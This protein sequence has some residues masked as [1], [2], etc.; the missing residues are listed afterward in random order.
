MAVVRAWSRANCRQSEW[1]SYADSKSG[2]PTLLQFGTFICC[3]DEMFSDIEHFISNTDCFALEELS[4]YCLAI[5]S[6]F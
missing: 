2:P 1:R 5:I 4:C 3:L 6:F